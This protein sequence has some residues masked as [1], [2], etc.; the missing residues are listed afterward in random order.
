MTL[1]ESSSALT[2]YCPL[3]G[4]QI[5]KMGASCEECSAQNNRWLI[6]N[7]GYIYEEEW[8]MFDD[9]M[10]KLIR[11]VSITIVIVLVISLIFHFITPDI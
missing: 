2:P 9:F 7:T 4:S 5:N 10:K 3:C 6:F 11:V 1:D 8:I